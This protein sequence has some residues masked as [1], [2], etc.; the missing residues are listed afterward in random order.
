MKKLLCAALAVGLLAVVTAMQ[1]GA[2]GT[3]AKVHA[4][5]KDKLVVESGGEIEFKTGST[6]TV[7]N[8]TIDTDKLGSDAVTTA[9]IADGAVTAGK[10]GTGAVT[11]VKVDADAVDTTKLDSP[12]AP[13]AGRLLCY[14]D[15]GKIGKVTAALAADGALD[16]GKGTGC[17]AV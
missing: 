14:T 10:I 16:S 8:G 7:P 2:Q 4:S 9:K 15:D 13:A 5:G 6:L 12:A 11:K 17:E 1:V 3:V